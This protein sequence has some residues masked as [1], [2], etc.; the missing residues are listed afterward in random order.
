MG[1]CDPAEVNEALDDK[2]NEI[3]CHWTS[4]RR[5]HGDM[6]GELLQRIAADKKSVLDLVASLANEDIYN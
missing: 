5:K 1:F 2:I 3:Y 4:V 6:D